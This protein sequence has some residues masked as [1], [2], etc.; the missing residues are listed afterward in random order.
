MSSD[1]S[2]SSTIIKNSLLPRGNS[3]INFNALV[4]LFPTE[5]FAKQTFTDADILLKYSQRKTLPNT[6]NSSAGQECTFQIKSKEKVVTKRL[7]RRV[8]KISKKEKKGED[9]NFNFNSQLKS[10]CFKNDDDK[11]TQ[12]LQNLSSLK[13][14][15]K[16][17]RLHVQDQR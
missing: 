8:R 9:V 16:R 10:H 15:K 4:T 2:S 17:T 11:R 7:A 14:K 13:R 12:M 3:E 1:A 5:T 6:E